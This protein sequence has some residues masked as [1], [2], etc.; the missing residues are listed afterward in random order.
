MRHNH[1]AERQAGEREHTC[2]SHRAEDWE[3]RQGSDYFVCGIKDFAL[4]SGGNGK[5]G[6][7]GKQRPDQICDLERP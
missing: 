2:G 5:P 1:R 7:D 6:K 4:Y 3:G